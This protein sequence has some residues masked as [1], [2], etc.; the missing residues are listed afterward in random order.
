MDYDA[1]ARRAEKD[2]EAILRG[3]APVLSQGAEVTVNGRK[4]QV[5]NGEGLLL[6]LVGGLEQRITGVANE[7]V[8]IKGLIEELKDRLPELKLRKCAKCGGPMPENLSLGAKYCTD[9][10]KQSAYLDRKAKRTGEAP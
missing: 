6:Q 10:C 9:S 3:G 1:I 4:M 7:V 2:R 8:A 5:S